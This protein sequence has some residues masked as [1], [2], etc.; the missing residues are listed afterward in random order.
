MAFTDSEIARM[1][2][3]LGYNVLGFDAS[4]YIGITSVFDSVIQSSALSG[5]ATTSAAAVSEATTPTPATIVVASATDLAAGV[6]IVVDVDSRAETVTIQHVSGTNVTAIFSKAHSGTYPV[7]VESGET[8]AREILAQIKELDSQTVSRLT[9][10]IQKAPTRGR[11]T[12]LCRIQK[13]HVRR[14]VLSRPRA[15]RAASLGN[16]CKLPPSNAR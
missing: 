2:F 10:R 8:I 12:W 6:R 15:V 5:A 16:R 9:A 14:T 3:E 7:A 4:P 1:R 11:P 13:Q